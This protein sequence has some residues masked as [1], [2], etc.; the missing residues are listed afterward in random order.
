MATLY[1]VGSWTSGGYTG[2]LATSYT[3]TTDIT[4]NVSN[5]TVTVTWSG[6]RSS[7]T[8]YGNGLRVRVG[9]QWW[10]AVAAGGNANTARGG[11][12]H[13]FTVPHNNDGTGSVTIYTDADISG[14][15]PDFK[16]KSATVT[17]TTI[18]RGHTFTLN[19]TM[20]T[21]GQ[22]VT[23]TATKNVEAYRSTITWD[24]GVS[25]GT[26]TTND[27]GTSWGISYDT[28]AAG[29]PTGITKNV[30]IICQTI[31]FETG[32]VVSETTLYVAVNT[33]SIVL[34]LYDDGTDA[35][36]TIGERAVKGGM[37]VYTDAEFG[38][39]GKPVNVN[40]LHSFSIGRFEKIW[41]QSIP[42][43]M[44]ATTLNVDLSKYEAI[45]IVTAT[46]GYFNYALTT[47]ID[48]QWQGDTHRTKVTE[49][50][51]GRMVARYFAITETGIEVGNGYRFNT[52]ASSTSTT[53]N[54]I[55]IPVYILGVH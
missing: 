28:L 21:A 9:T 15:N 8:L 52:Y 45:V 33:G 55:V 38:K 12:S 48:G 5:V 32:N 13:T 41:S 36:V 7:A 19:E 4:T 53:D 2:T 26:I 11:L 46:G 1:T 18:P 16:S 35:G 27:A 20:L 6:N 43:S 37:N 14:G 22:S 54:A 31:N 23:L 34:S 50:Q 42:S 44:A 40:Y 47:R 30:S 29:L 10:T 25:Q 39:E 17:L 3:E 51:G 24:N 49:Q